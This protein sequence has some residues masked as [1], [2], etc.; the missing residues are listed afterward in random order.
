MSKS[1]LTPRSSGISHNYDLFEFHQ[2]LS[3]EADRSGK[4]KTGVTI[5]C[6]KAGVS[7]DGHSIIAVATSNSKTLD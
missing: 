2:I 3:L 7:P 1:N 5:T 4:T 6:L